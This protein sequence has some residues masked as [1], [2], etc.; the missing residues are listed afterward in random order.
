MLSQPSFLSLVQQ[1]LVAAERRAC[2]RCAAV[3]GLTAARCGSAWRTSH[4]CSRYPPV[5][6]QSLRDALRHHCEASI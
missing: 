1:Y 3:G 2:P 6:A 4:R 5:A